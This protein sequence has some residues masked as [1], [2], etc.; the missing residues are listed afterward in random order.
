MVGKALK[1]TYIERKNTD[2][3]LQIGN[4]IKHK[5]LLDLKLDSTILKSYH[6]KE[7]H[8][9][10][11]VLIKIPFNSNID[12]KK[13]IIDFFKPNEIFCNGGVYSFDNQN[14][15]I[16]FIPIAENN[17][18]IAQTYGFYDPLG[19]IMGK[20]YHKFGFDVR[21]AARIKFGTSFTERGFDLLSGRQQEELLTSQEKRKE[22]KQNNEQL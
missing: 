20:T 11:D 22:K 16:D 7:T 13:Y 5:I 4:K 10:L 9:D 18:E 8:G 12:F 14:F 6:N 3:F 19:N 1:N 15:Q 2:E 21:T 17:W